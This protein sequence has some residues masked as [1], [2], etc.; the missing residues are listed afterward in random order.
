MN[1]KFLE[2]YNRE[3]QFI[4]EMGGE[5][6]K[7]YPKIAA[8]LD[9]GGTEC[10]DPY[11]ERLLESFAFLTARVQ[12]KMEAEFPRFTQ[13]L[14]EIVYPHYLAPLPSMTVVEIRPDLQGGISEEG[15]QLPRHTRLFSNTGAK[16]RSKCEFQTAHELTLWPVKLKEASY[17]PLGE[18]LRYAGSSVKGVKAG[19]CL[20]LQTV[21]EIGF[22]EMQIDHLPFYLHGTGALPGEL[23]ELIIGHGAA[24][25]IKDK[26]ADGKTHVLHKSCIESLGFGENE[27][28]L[29]YTAASFQGY[30]LLQE[31]FALPQRFLFFQ[32]RQLNSA[33]QCCRGD[34]VEIVILLDSAKDELEDVISSDHFKLN[35]TPAI[36]LFP[37]RTDR[38]HLDQYS[39]EHHLVIDRTRPQDFE[40]FSILEVAGYG[41]GSKNEQ[42]FRP[43]YSDRQDS[44]IQGDFAYYT[45]RRQ[46]T[47]EAAQ[48]GIGKLKTDYVGSE[49][50]LSLVD[51]GELPYRTDL[52]QLGVRTLCTNRSLP[53]LMLVG[54]GKSDFTWEISAPIESI[55]CLAGPTDPKPSHAEGSHAWRLINH[56]TLNYL[57]LINNDSRQGAT[58]LRDLLRLYGDFSE[59]AIAKQIE[60]LLTVHSRSVTMR[61]PIKGPMTFGRGVEISVNFDES[62]FVGGSCFLLGAILERFFCKYVSIN[63]FTQ[64]VIKTR[65]R[66]EIM[67]WPVRTGTRTLI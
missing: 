39:S 22:H 36:N 34:E 15:F 54:E 20:K 3:L 27:A 26:T 12:L 32:L 30:R 50:F 25:V 52:R 17:L 10:A 47:L 31:Y 14:L 67:R 51:A 65:E 18:A 44:G 38:I 61:V 58:A 7:R 49:L 35:C 56:L 33:L 19:L 46:P 64:V 16:G 66:G 11:V 5:F 9:L 63:S 41:A 1:P 53:K 59:P 60:G 43:F 8:G 24:V 13:H 28:L 4:R 23:Y 62:S 42:I 6:A 37:K 55:H 57:S 40:V 21:L 2:H 48:S 29:P 45:V